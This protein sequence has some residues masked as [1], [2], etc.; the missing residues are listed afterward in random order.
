MSGAAPARVLIIEDNAMVA[1]GLALILRPFGPVVV[2]SL[3]ELPAALERIPEGAVVL[4]DLVLEDGGGDQIHALLSEARPDLLTRLFWL[5]G[6]GSSLDRYATTVAD[7]GRPVVYKPIAP[8]E[9]RALVKGA[10]DD[11]DDES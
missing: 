4:S 1:R 6:G 9:L 11:E 3:A 8:L 7:S 5:T 10:L 2:P